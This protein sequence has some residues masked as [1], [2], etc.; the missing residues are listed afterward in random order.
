LEKQVQTPIQ[1]LVVNLLGIK[2]ENA[3]M[4]SVVAFAI[5]AIVGGGISTIVGGGISTI[6]GGGISA[7]V[8]GGISAIV[9]GGISAIVGGG[10]SA[11]GG[12]SIIIASTCRNSQCEKSNQSKFQKFVPQSHLFLSN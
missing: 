10:I 6:V 8:G 9:G 5:S 3:R 7:I 11:I 4:K 12:V 1:A 2:L